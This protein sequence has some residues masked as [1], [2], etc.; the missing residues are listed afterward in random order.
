M[1]IARMTYSYSTRSAG[2]AGPT[3]IGYTIQ[4]NAI[5]AQAGDGF[6]TYNSTGAKAWDEDDSGGIGAGENDWH[7]N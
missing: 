1:R 2:G 3:A 6:M 7:E 5:Q 4:A